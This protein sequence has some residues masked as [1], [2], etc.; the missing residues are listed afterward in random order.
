MHVLLVGVWASL[1]EGDPLNRNLAAC[2]SRWR[3]ASHR[4]LRDPKKLLALDILDVSEQLSPV[5]PPTLRGQ[6]CSLL[7]GRLF[8]V[9][10]PSDGMLTSEWFPFHHEHSVIRNSSG[11]KAFAGLEGS[12]C[13]VCSRG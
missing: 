10:P 9:M 8:A 7:P 1:C 11:A 12:V 2:G 6:M 4:T 5:L 3:R 13:P